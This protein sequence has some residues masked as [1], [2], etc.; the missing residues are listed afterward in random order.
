MVFMFDRKPALEM[1]NIVRKRSQVKFLAQEHGRTTARNRL[2]KLV[3]CSISLQNEQQY[4]VTIISLV[5]PVWY[6]AVI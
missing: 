4:V 3:N 2:L 5:S 1:I 6:G